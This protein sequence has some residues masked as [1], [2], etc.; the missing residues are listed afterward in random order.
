MCI[1]CNRKSKTKKML[2]DWRIF[3]DNLDRP[4]DSS[5]I[6]GRFKDLFVVSIYLNQDTHLFVFM[7]KQKRYYSKPHIL[8]EMHK[9]SEWCLIFLLVACIMCSHFSI[10]FL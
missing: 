6:Y 2:N 3:L 10:M 8:I 9:Q 4:R 1:V 5:N 7:V